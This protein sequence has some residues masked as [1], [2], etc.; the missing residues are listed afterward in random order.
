MIN[1]HKFGHS[2]RTNVSERLLS[3]PDFI[4]LHLFKCYVLGDDDVMRLGIEGAL[5]DWRTGASWPLRTGYL[6][7]TCA[8]GGYSFVGED[9]ES[10]HHVMQNFG[11]EGR[12][13]YVV[14]L[15]PKGNAPH[16]VGMVRGPSKGR[17]KRPTYWYRTAHGRYA[18]TRA[19]FKRA[20]ELLGE[21]V[22]TL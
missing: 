11:D 14:R 12:G 20:A 19:G 18:L 10:T 5:R 7:N 13:G 8:S 4:V 22:N 9:F 16:R 2:P 17:F 15:G 3:N 21:Y 6:F 1:L